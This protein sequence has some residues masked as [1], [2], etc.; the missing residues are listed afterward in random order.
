MSAKVVVPDRIISS[1][2]RRVPAFTNAAVT[3][4]FSAGKMNFCSQSMSRRSSAMPRKST[5]GACPCVLTRP[6]ITIASRAS[7]T[8]RA[9]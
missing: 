1:A 7:S 9:V 8:S 5:M 3:F 2:A 4:F 6:G